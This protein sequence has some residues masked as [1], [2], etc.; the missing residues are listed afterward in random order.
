MLFNRLHGVY[1]V[2][3]QISDFAFFNKRTFFNYDIGILGI[4]GIH[5]FLSF[6]GIQGF[7]GFQ[8]FATQSVP[9]IPLDNLF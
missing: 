5:G 9:K 2:W 6:H 1:A 3:F 8:A 4:Q 7:D